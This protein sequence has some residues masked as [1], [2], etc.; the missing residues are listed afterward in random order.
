MCNELNLLEKR[1]AYI[2]QG[3]DVIK[4]ESIF[5]SRK[6]QNIQQVA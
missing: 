2:I 5:E 1:N 4:N 6:E 3:C